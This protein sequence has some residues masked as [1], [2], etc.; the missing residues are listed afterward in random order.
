M[1]FYIP[2]AIG[3]KHSIVM[4]QLKKVA[5]QYIL[6]RLQVVIDFLLH[7]LGL[8]KNLQYKC[9]LNLFLVLFLINLHY[10]SFLMNISGYILKESKAF[11]L[12]TQISD[13]KLFFKETTYSHFPVVEENKLIGLISETD[14]QGIESDNDKISTYQYL[15]IQFCTNENNN[16]LEILKVFAFNETNLIPVIDSN[17]KYIG[18]LDLIDIL[19]VYNGTPFLNDEGTILYIE[20]GVKDY[21]FSEIC[22]IV[23]SNKGKFLGGFI[24][25]ID[26]TSVQIMLKF[27]CEDVNEIIQTFRRYQYHVLSKHK[28]DFYFEDL[29]DRSNYLR[30]YLNI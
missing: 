11:S 29:E 25:E 24:S 21:S 30:K 19:H 14:I 13:V 9:L 23:E 28:E 15:F 20:K 12:Q 3:I 16:L 4:V 27:T 22:Q 6:Q 5:K 1:T 17:Q 8:I 10:N 7:N 26:E 18:Y 2:I